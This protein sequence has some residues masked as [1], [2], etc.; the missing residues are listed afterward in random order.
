MTESVRKQ[1]GQWFTAREIQ[2]FFSA[3]TDTECA[4][5]IGTLSTL[6]PADREKMRRGLWATARAQGRI[7]RQARRGKSVFGR[8]LV[9]AG[10]WEKL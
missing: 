1:L 4:E 5:L 9:E 7:K 8:M 3:R 10:R 6:S 2:V